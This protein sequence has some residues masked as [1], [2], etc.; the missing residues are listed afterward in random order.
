[1]Q[2]QKELP[3]LSC[4][5]NAASWRMVIMA[6]IRWV[7]RWRTVKASPAWDVWTMIHVRMV[8]EWTQ[9]ICYGMYYWLTNISRA[10]PMRLTSARQISRDPSNEMRKYD[11]DSIRYGCSSFA[12]GRWCLDP[13]VRA[14]GSIVIL[15]IR[16]LEW[17]VLARETEN[18]N[19]IYSSKL[20]IAWV[21]WEPKARG[22]Q[23]VPF[24][25]RNKPVAAM[26]SRATGIDTQGATVRGLCEIDN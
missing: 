12:S 23:S 17:V 15:Q 22:C 13:V 19:M 26:G 25:L 3:P 7:L 11:V 6:C 9:N 18:K 4:Q 2:R 5:T 1:M 14:S 8:F 10:S 16:E 20:S 24:R 21:N